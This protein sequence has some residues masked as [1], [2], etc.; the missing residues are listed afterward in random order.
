M[1]KR[2]EQIPQEDAAWQHDDDARGDVDV[3]EFEQ[4]LHEDNH[5]AIRTRWGDLE[6]DDVISEE[7][8]GAWARAS[9]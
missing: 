8:L 3:E 2:D 5:G 4:Q 9:S 6:P 1:V 7:M